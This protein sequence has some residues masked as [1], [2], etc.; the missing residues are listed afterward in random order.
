MHGEE[1][2][3]QPLKVSHLSRCLLCVDIAWPAESAVVGMEALRCAKE[4]LSLS[5]QP[6]GLWQCQGVSRPDRTGPGDI[7]ICLQH[8]RSGSQSAVSGSLGAGLPGR[9]LSSRLPKAWHTS[10]GCGLSQSGWWELPECRLTYAGEQTTWSGGRAPGGLLSALPQHGP[11]LTPSGQFT[12]FPH[13]WALFPCPWRLA[14]ACFLSGHLLWLTPK[15]TH[16]DPCDPPSHAFGVLQLCE[17]A[18]PQNCH[19]WRCERPINKDTGLMS[20]EGLLA[21]CHQLGDGVHTAGS[22][23]TQGFLLQ[24]SHLGKCRPTSAQPS[25][26]ISASTAGRRARRERP[27]SATTCTEAV[28]PTQHPSLR[29]SSKSSP[30]NPWGV[31]QSVFVFRRA[32]PASGRLTGSWLMR[33]LPVIRNFLSLWSKPSRPSCYCYCVGF[34]LGESANTFLLKNTTCFPRR[35]RTLLRD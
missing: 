32:S 4:L 8:L 21:G 1:D 20:G 13:V 22:S 25:A 24:C 29:C 16:T 2:I 26:Q 5:E 23:S 15:S 34:G 31:V 17:A 9:Q 7:G 27:A 28:G 19:N 11:P 14:A 6:S 12:H 18:S 30:S 10:L 35:P 33:P 3:N